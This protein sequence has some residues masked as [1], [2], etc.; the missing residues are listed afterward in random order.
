MDGQL[1][2]PVDA[3]AAQHQA[4]QW[5]HETLHR[6]GEVGPRGSEERFRGDCVCLEGVC[7]DCVPLD[8]VQLLLA[9]SYRSA[10]LR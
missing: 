1:L 2:H 9:G 7:L 10:L 5:G 4:T 3:D 8:G 6:R